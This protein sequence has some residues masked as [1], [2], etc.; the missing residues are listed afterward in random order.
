[1]ILGQILAHKRAEVA[2]RRLQTPIDQLQARAEQRFEVQ[3][4]AAT[5]AHECADDHA[6][7]SALKAPGVSLIAEAKKQ[8]PSGGVFRQDYR[9]TDLALAYVAGGAS[10]VSVLTDEL[11]F[12]GRL[13]HVT[14]VGDALRAKAIAAPVL[15]KDFV[16]DAYQVYETYVAGA[17]ALLLIVAALADAELVSLLELASGLGL[18]ALVETHDITEVRRAVH[19]GARVIG[20]NNRDL[21]D[22][23]VDLNTFGRLR[24]AI[25]PDVVAVSESGVHEAGDVSLLRGMGADAVL[26]GTTLVASPDPQAKARELVSG[27]QV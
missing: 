21:R 16:V 24:E 3:S 12:G 14:M 11:Y 10:A 4:A 18:D 20:V 23:S 27:G 2:R 22:F 15:R 5:A 1:V 9:P 25:P 13:D 7:A 8:S 6:F 19:A 17:D 26:V